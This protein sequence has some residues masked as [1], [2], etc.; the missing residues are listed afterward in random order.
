MNALTEQLL[1][2][3]KIPHSSF[4]LAQFRDEAMNKQYN[5]YLL[6]T[7]KEKFVMKSGETE[8]QKYRQYFSSGRFPV[9]KIWPNTVTFE[10]KTWFLMEYLTG[11]DLRGADLNTVLLAARELALLHSKFW[12]EPQSEQP[13]DQYSGYYRRFIPR[14]PESPAL[15]N[16]L[17]QLISRMKQ[18]PRT[19]IH[20]DLLPINVQVTDQGIR[21]MDWQYCGLYPY[22]MDICRLLVHEAGELGSSF[23][24][25]IRTAAF[26]T[27][28]GTLISTGC[29]A[30]TKETYQSDIRL[31]TIAELVSCLQQ[32][33]RAQWQDFLWDYYKRIL[34]L[35]D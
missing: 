30:L 29:T 21:F 19:L 20:D 26:D 11:Q 27:Y 14:F 22:F 13:E 1:H 33:D 4:S 17:A 12:T 34:A 5:V 15:Q 2:E 16:T 18:C 25:E 28:Y 3:N 31:G 32:E 24:E 9:P 7:G 35:S 8:L 23:S 10:S 6:D